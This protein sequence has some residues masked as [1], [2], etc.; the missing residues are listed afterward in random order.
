MHRQLLQDVAHRQVD[1]DV[2]QREEAGHEGVVGEVG[3]VRL[4]RDRGAQQFHLATA[5]GGDLHQRIGRV[6]VGQVVG[7]DQ[8]LQPALQ[9]AA[10]EDGDCLREAADLRPR[11]DGNRVDET[12]QVVGELGLLA[13]D[14]FNLA[15]VA[16]L[17]DDVEELGQLQA[18]EVRFLAGGRVACRQEVAAVEVEAL[19]LQPAEHLVCADIGG[20]LPETGLVEVHQVERR[21]FLAGECRV[22][23]YGIEIGNRDLLQDFGGV[24]VKTEAVALAVQLVAVLHRLLVVEHGGGEDEHDLT[25]F[26]RVDELG[27]AQVVRTDGDDQRHGVCQRRDRRAGK[28]PDVVGA[29]GR[30]AFPRLPVERHPAAVGG[31]D[32]TE[33]KE[34][35]GHGCFC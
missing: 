4:R 25:G 21:E 9:L 18:S 24:D 33:E 26:E 16:V 2:E 8:Q 35:C 29:V 32:G 3:N 12:Q 30:G 11:T 6:A 19:F 20:D 17:L 14:R 23:A 15:R 5:R 34:G 10:A 1:Q 28:T 31:E 22:E 7:V 13:E 27:V